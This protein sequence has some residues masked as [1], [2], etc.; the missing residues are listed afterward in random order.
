MS[1]KLYLVVLFFVFVGCERTEL[2]FSNTLNEKNKIVGESITLKNLEYKN[3]IKN[4]LTNIKVYSMDS[5]LQRWYYIKDIDYVIEGNKIRRTVNSSIPNFINHHVIY[6][7]NGTFTFNY[8]PKNP[9]LTIP[10]QIYV[11][12]NFL[13]TVQIQGKFSSDFLSL[14]L[15]EKLK[16]KEQ[17]RIG[18]LGTSI[19]SGA[20]TLDHYYNNSDKDT[21]PYLISKMIEKVYRVDV[22]TKNYSNNGA[23]ASVT[24]DSVLDILQ[25]ENDLVFI[26]FGM[27]DHIYSFW[28]SR[29]EDFKMNMEK[30][31]QEFQHRN[32]DVILVGFF[33][34]NKNWDHEFPESTSAYNN[35]LQG[36]ALNYGVYFADVNKEFSKYSE[37]KIIQDFCGDYLHHPTSFGHKLYYKTIIPVFLS[38]EFSDGYIYGLL[39]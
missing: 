9:P 36:L 38:D 18:A 7:P 10:Y 5:S 28:S 20:H 1:Y 19:T 32:I 16:N 25:D 4:E 37:E 23:S 39:N 6:N 12:Y 3:L 14:R 2:D 8:S 22:V 26:E 34:Q 35:V 27:N 24:S 33:Q 17:I 31:V 29:L 30:L 21:Y 11:D 13:D 15:K